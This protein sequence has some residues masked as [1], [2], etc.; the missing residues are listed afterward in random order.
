MSLKF[1]SLFCPSRSTSASSAI[2]PRHA[3]RYESTTFLN[4][5][6]FDSFLALR[7]FSCR[8]R[9]FTAFLVSLLRICLFANFGRPID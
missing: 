6:S 1:Q 5:T 9:G 8:I 4:V 7:G 3:R 2:Q